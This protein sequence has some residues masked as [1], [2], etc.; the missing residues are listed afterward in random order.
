MA[1]LHLTTISREPSTAFRHKGSFFCN[2]CTCTSNSV[3]GR[4]ELRFYNFPLR[5]NEHCQCFSCTKHYG[6][7]VPVAMFLFYGEWIV[8]DILILIPRLV[9]SATGHKERKLN[10]HVYSFLLFAPQGLAIS[11]VLR[12]RK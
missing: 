4:F 1:A 3:H 12:Y 7:D 2:I 11:L 9:V 6:Y 10:E 8:S 5:I